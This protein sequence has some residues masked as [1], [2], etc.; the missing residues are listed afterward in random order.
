VAPVSVAAA[1]D[2]NRRS[3]CPRSP[4]GSRSW[5]I[6]PSVTV[7]HPRAAS[8]S[9]NPAAAPTYPA[10]P[11][12]VSSSLPYSLC[13]SCRLD[14]PH[15]T[16]VGNMSSS[17]RSV[18]RH[19]NRFSKSRRNWF[20]RRSKRRLDTGRTGHSPPCGDRWRAASG[21]PITWSI[22]PGVCPRRGGACCSLPTEQP[23]AHAGEPTKPVGF[24]CRRSH[25]D[26][27]HR[28]VGALTRHL[29]TRLSTPPHAIARLPQ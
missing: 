6:S 4:W 13:C 23:P 1:H 12:C 5:P 2:G 17:R 11:S 22:R 15:F 14:R 29:L 3:A 9:G 25:L 27:G 26:P 18:N 19:V 28:G 7:S 10:G 21:S 24:L 20:T 16:A 8:V